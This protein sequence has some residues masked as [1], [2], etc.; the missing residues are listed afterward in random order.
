MAHVTSAPEGNC[1][2]VHGGWIRARV[3]CMLR[4]VL[5]DLRITLGSPS[6]KKGAA[7]GR[8]PSS[9][10]SSLGVLLRN[11]QIRLSP[12]SLKVPPV[13]IVKRR[14]LKG[15]PSP[16]TSFFS[17]FWAPSPSSWDS[18]NSLALSMQFA[19]PQPS[20]SSVP[21]WGQSGCGNA[22]VPGAAF[23]GPQA[24]CP[25]VLLPFLAPLLRSQFG[26]QIERSECKVRPGSPAALGVCLTRRGCTASS[27]WLGL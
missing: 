4:A 15:L 14:Y 13:R 8:P 12:P 27:G 5:K 7:L 1:S 6:G 22:T 21:S 26:L 20:I 18:S 11:P 3:W 19:P 16:S 9:L 2:C 25:F 23:P 17:P 24:Q 10:P